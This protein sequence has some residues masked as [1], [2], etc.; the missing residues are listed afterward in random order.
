MPSSTRCGSSTATSSGWRSR[1]PTYGRRSR[2]S[3]GRAAYSTG[4]VLPDAPTSTSGP[5]H[6]FTSSLLPFPVHSQR[7][8]LLQEL[9]ERLKQTETRADTYEKKLEVSSRT[10]GSLKSGI[11]GIFTRLGCDKAHPAG[12]KDLVGDG[13]ISE[14]NMMQY[15]GVIEHKLNDLLQDYLSRQGPEGAAI[16]AAV[17]GPGPQAAQAVGA[18]SVTDPPSVAAELEEGDG[19]DGE[20]LA[21]DVPLSREALEARVQQAMQRKKAASRAATAAAPARPYMGGL[22]GAPSKKM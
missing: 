1:S 18:V 11:L 14:N 17:M 15:L 10:I 8:K 2:G 22:R 16:Y 7:K 13:G 5:R 9:E 12:S 4:G 20:E 21:E 19:D 6:G 3:R